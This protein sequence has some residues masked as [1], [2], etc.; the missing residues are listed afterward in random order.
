LKNSED[1]LADLV[2]QFMSYDENDP[3]SN[4]SSLKQIGAGSAP[5]TLL[6]HITVPNFTFD[7]LVSK[8]QLHR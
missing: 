6:L 4:Y 8:I 5:L 2:S 7:F 3:R 1:D